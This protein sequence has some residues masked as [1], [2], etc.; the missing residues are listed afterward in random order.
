LYDAPAVAS[1]ILAS[2]VQDEPPLVDWRSHTFQPPPRLGPVFLV[3]L[4]CSGHSEA[5]N[6]R[7]KA[8]RRARAGVR[9]VTNRTLKWTRL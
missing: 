2:G 9:G 4:P 3:L 7:R 1:E 6:P 5:A 8:L